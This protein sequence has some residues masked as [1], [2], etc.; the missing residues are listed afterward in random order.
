LGGNCV[1]YSSFDANCA[2]FITNTATCSS[3]YSGYYIGGNGVTGKCTFGNQYCASFT[4]DGTGKCGSCWQGYTLSLGV[5]SYGSPPKDPYCA[6]FSGTNCLKC[7][8]GYYIDGNGVTGKCVPGNQYCANYTTDGTGKCGSCW[9]GY[10]LFLGVCS[11]VSLPK[12]PYCASFSGTICLKCYTG[13]YIDGNGVTGKCVP[14]N[15]YCANYTT[16]GTGKCGSCWPSYTIQNGNCV[17]ASNLNTPRDPF[18]SKFVSATT[19]CISCYVGYFVN[20][21]V[22][23]RCAPANQYCATYSMLGGACTSCY[24][25]YRLSGKTPNSCVYP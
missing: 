17:V 7:Y 18:C 11:Y 22:D 16:D 12:D 13:Y 20:V 2:R 6:S 1:I 8:T 25:P 24:N 21:N 19:T 23:G 3:C 4:T 14:G 9:P 10:T 5:C 15:Q